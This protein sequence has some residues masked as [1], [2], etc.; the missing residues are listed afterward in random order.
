MGLYAKLQKKPALFLSATGMQLDDFQRLLPQFEAAYAQQEAQR[1]SRVVK[2]GAPRQR[3]AGGGASFSTAL[4]ERL[5]MLLVYY[6]MYVT[7]EFMTLLF[8][9]EDKATICRAIRQMR[10][11][12]EAVLP[13]PERA[14]RTVFT[15]ARQETD[16]RQ[17]RL[18]ERLGRRI[19]NLEDFL[20][21][22]PEFTL[23]IDGTEQ[24]KQKPQDK[25]KRKSDYSGKKRRHTLKQ[26]V[27]ST[28][29]GLILDQSPSCGGRRHD[30]SVFKEHLREG[31]LGQAMQEQVP[32]LRVT[33]YTDSGFTGI[34]QLSLPITTRVVER[35]RRGHPLT[36][37]Q[38]VLNR[39]RARERIKVEHSIGRRK[40]YRIAAEVYRNRD[41][42][43]DATM[44]IVAGLSNLRL[45]GSLAQ[46]T[47]VDL[48]EVSI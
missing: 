31:T 4:P 23:L 44:T 46:Q 10:P 13:V 32:Y 33:A 2:T 29:S 22:Y 7:Q 28:P 12:F 45:Y 1:K 19:N 43:Y 21:E 35:A 24:P 9:V 40:K 38:K 17:K 30:F 47:G 8:E 16:R 37:E 11:V 42:D 6:R 15:L 26:I 48:L 18:E 5:L 27:T 39:V 36:P 41:E 25:D 14:M 3:R 34:E 20:H